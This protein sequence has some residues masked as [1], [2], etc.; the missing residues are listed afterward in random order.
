MGLHDGRGRWG[1]GTGSAPEGGGHGHKLLEFR[2]CLDGVLRH[3]IRILGVAVWIQ[4][5]D[6]MILMG[7][8]QQEIL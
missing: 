5:L 7:P 8:I 1:L 4:E 3:R 6:S 2:K